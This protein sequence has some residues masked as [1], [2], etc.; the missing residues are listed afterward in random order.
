ME[1]IEGDT[2][3]NCH[4]MPIAWGITASKVY[5]A[6]WIIVLGAALLILSVYAVQVRWWWL[7]VYIVATML[8]P[9]YFIYG[10]LR[11]A[12]QSHDFGTISSL[13]KMV[14]LFGILSMLFFKWYIG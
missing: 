11:V 2:K 1:D 9:L 6:V 5:T 8:T 12:M 13:V 3:Y 4:T 14:M 10:K 7:A